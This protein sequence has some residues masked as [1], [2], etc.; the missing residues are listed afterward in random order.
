MKKRYM[1]EIEVDE[2]NIAELDPNYS[3]N[4][5][6]PEEFIDSLLKDFIYEGETNMQEDGLK[7]WGY[8]KRVIRPLSYEPMM[9]EQYNSPFIDAIVEQINFDLNDGYKEAFDELLRFI[10]RTN[11]V[12]YLPE[13]EWE[14][15]MT[16]EELEN[17]Y[18]GRSKQ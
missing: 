8:A 13:E 3:I 10:P 15:W 12:Q 18:R 11:L 5:E 6:N 1:I 14:K 16:E 17:I 2:E 7:E 9:N 4:Y